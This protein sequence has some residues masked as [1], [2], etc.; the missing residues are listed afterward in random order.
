MSAA[1]PTAPALSRR[2]LRRHEVRR[3]QRLPRHR[4]V[5][6]PFAQ[7]FGQAEVGDPRLIQPVDEH[8]GRFEVPVQHSAPVG[9]GD[10]F[11]D[12]L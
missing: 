11:G 3:A 6:A 9:I 7:P 1:G 8:V 5:A 12:G 2:L 4:Q 10:R